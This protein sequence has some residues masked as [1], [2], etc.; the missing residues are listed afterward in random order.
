[1]T[2]GPYNSGRANRGFMAESAH[3]MADTHIV[4]LMYHALEL[5]GRKLRRTEPG[6]LRYVLSEQTFQSQMRW[7]KDA[8]FRGLSVS[9]AL[10]YPQEPSVCITFDDG[11]ETDLIAAAPILREA[12]FNA[13]FYITTGYLGTPAHLSRDQM[14]ELEAQGFELGC[15][16]KSHPY[17]PDISDSELRRETVDAKI[18]LEQMLGHAVEHFSCPGGRYDERTLEMARRAGFRSVANSSFYSNSAATNP[19]KLGRV[20]MLRDMPQEEFAALCN[21]RGLWKKRWQDD[22]RRTTRRFLGN[23]AYDR[24]RS[25]LLRLHEG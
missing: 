13:T 7:L 17:L 4:F 12:G 23:R 10:R 2:N 8:G 24:V 15:H 11:C 19:Y 5:A 14:R 22:A 21:N 1:M 9:E 20:A 3:F 25:V 16:S 6:Y 18:E